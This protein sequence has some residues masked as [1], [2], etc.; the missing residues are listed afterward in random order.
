VEGVKGCWVLEGGGCWKERQ[1]VVLASLQPLRSTHP[2]LQSPHHISNP[3]HTQTTLRLPIQHAPA[4]LPTPHVGTSSFGMS[5]VNAHAI[6]SAAPASSSAPAPA[7]T[8]HGAAAQ[9]ILLQRRDFLQV[10]GLP[11]GHPLLY[12]ASALAGGTPVSKATSLAAERDQMVVEFAVPL[13]ARPRLA[14]LWDHRVRGVALLPAAAFLEMGAAAARALLP[15]PG[16]S[17]PPALA[18]TVL[19]APLVLPEQRVGGGASEA[20]GVLM[21]KCAV[22]AAAGTL[23]ISSSLVNGG[24]SSGGVQARLSTLHVRSTV[25][26]L[27]APPPL[28]PSPAAA[29]DLAAARQAPPSADTLRAAC[30]TPTDVAAVYSALDAA[31][32]QYG[33]AF[34][35]L[36]AVHQG[37]GKAAGC[38]T[39]G[40]SDAADGYAVHPATLDSLLQLGATVPEAAERQRAAMVPA[41]VALFAAAADVGVESTAVWGL[42]QRGVGGCAAA[43]AAGAGLSTLRDHRLVAS[44]GS[45]ACTVEGLEARPVHAQQLQSGAAAASAQHTRMQQKM[46]SEEDEGGDVLYE[47]DWVVDEQAAAPHHVA[48]AG[49]C[50]SLQLV[51]HRRSS[52]AVQLAASA[53]AAVQALPAAAGAAGGLLAL[54]GGGSIS[55]SSTSSAA[56]R[57]LLRSWGQEQ[58]SLTLSAWGSDRQ[59][60]RPVAAH[61]TRSTALSVL[62]PGA[63]PAGTMDGYGHRAC[64]AT[65]RAPVLR[66]SWANS[67]PAPFNL[68]PRPRGALSSLVPQPVSLALQEEGT[69]LLAVKAVGLNFRDVLNVSGSWGGVGWWWGVVVALFMCWE[70]II[71]CNRLTCLFTHTPSTNHLQPPL[72]HRS[73]ACT[74]EMREIRALTAQLLC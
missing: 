74:L 67:S 27:A 15:P 46:S 22:S 69:A 65:T 72:N 7:R 63:L 56:I 32:L 43:A 58:S 8:A 30:S 57:G 39:G 4:V 1:G 49:S 70:L 9:P 12:H 28:A 66:A 29:T 2:P 45:L 31:G 55:S 5:G 36:S 6:L 64:A 38:L 41:S 17:A 35:R 71:P 59:A 24:G 25:A 62:P 52:T 18:G 51:S 3:N 40:A 16:H 10:A 68:S 34:R 53:L 60:A 26:T 73:W 13:A 21:L 23:S 50:A 11:I 48:P 61:S 54:D 20:S 37:L 33:P 42:A 14:F 47:I 19:A 44:S